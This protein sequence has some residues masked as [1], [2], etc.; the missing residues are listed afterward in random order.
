MFI[1]FK[2]HSFDRKPRKT[3]GVFEVLSGVQLDTKLYWQVKDQCEKR[4]CERSKVLGQVPPFR[5]LQN[6]LGLTTFENIESGDKVSEKTWPYA[7]SKKII[8]IF[9]QKKSDTQF[10]M[11]SSCHAPAC[12]AELYILI[13]NLSKI[14]V[15][16]KAPEF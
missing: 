9:C 8:I 13:Y 2:K 1:S 10:E 7:Q 11:R 3:S 4:E 16:V 12:V 5:T 14:S 6:K 15:L